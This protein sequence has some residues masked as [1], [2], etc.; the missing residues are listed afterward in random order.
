MA[1]IHT[2]TRDGDGQTRLVFHFPVPDIDNS[3]GVNYRIALVN[4]GL[5]G[6]SS[7]TEGTGAG[8]ISSAELAQIA[9]GELYEHSISV[10]VESGGTSG[11]Q[12]LATVRKFYLKAKDNVLNGLQQRLKYFGY[13]ASEE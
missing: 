11:P 4:S 2:L 5:G 10:P 13:T 6:M 8:Q 3:V 1:D 12:L 7:L 9:A